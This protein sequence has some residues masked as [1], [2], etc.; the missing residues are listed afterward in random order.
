MK[1]RRSPISDKFLDN[2]D[3]E[4]YVGINFDPDTPDPL[5]KSS[6]FKTGKEARN[7]NEGNA[8]AGS[9]LKSDRSF[10]WE[11]TSVLDHEDF[12]VTEKRSR[13]FNDWI[14]NEAGGLLSPVVKMKH[15]PEERSENGGTSDLAIISTGE[16][17]DDSYNISKFTLNT[18]ESEKHQTCGLHKKKIEAY[19]SEW[20][21]T[22][23]IDCILSDR[24]KQHSFTSLDK[25]ATKQKEVIEAN[26]SKVL[27]TKKTLEK[28]ESRVD[29]YLLDLTE[30][31][32]N[33]SKAVEEM[34]DLVIATINK[35][36]QDCLNNMNDVKERE[37]KLALEKK[38]KIQSHIQSIDQ[39]LN[40]QDQIDDLSDLEILSVAKQRDD[41]LK[42]ATKNA[43]DWTF[44]LSVLPEFKKDIEISNFGKQL[45]NA[46][47]EQESINPTKLSKQKSSSKKTSKV[48]KTGKVKPEP[49]TC[50]NKE[51]HSPPKLNETINTEISTPVCV[52]AKNP[53]FE[54]QQK[55]PATAP[56]P[57]HSHKAAKKETE[58]PPQ[59][60]TITTQVLNS[61]APKQQQ[62]KQPEGVKP[63]ASSF[64]Y[65][66]SK[67]MEKLT[68][69]HATKKNE[70]SKK[71]NESSGE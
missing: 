26:I 64:W 56:E 70:G 50:T 8:N 61:R 6:G 52:S 25:A 27:A 7:F 33:N 46:L 2:E 62:Q 69:F 3:K 57:N 37:E 38:E 32:Q 13:R 23:C 29:K 47:R 63:N 16:N 68:A 44:T 10:D 21:D 17:P 67:A 9:A 24:H 28:M 39:F 41:T 48:T 49:K 1:S 31:I 60:K 15:S 54:R 55:P 34:Y 66:P 20:K 43:V 30:R 22:L 35:K 14:R 53:F 59:P 58:L 40:I 12:D 19:C 45:K 11:F 5:I 71:A 4:N 65:Q 42:L 36:K 18:P 51:S